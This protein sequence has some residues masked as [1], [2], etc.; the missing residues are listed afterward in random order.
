MWTQR[1][2]YGNL[3]A[4]RAYPASLFALLLG[5][6]SP[7][8]ADLDPAVFLTPDLIGR[9]IQSTAVALDGDTLWFCVTAPEEVAG[10]C[11]RVRLWGISAPEM[12]R[13]EGWYARAALDELLATTSSIACFPRNWH[14]NRL[15]AVCISGHYVEWQNGFGPNLAARLGLSPTYPGSPGEMAIKPRAGPDFAW[16]MLA[17]GWATEY[18]IFTRAGIETAADFQAER[19]AGY[20]EAERWAREQR[21]G[22]WAGMPD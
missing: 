13:P 1:A 12:S 2:V 9:G 3:R 22:V 18:R 5:A 21:N 8:A 15:V 20:A 19:V 7:R 16:A 17:L 11:L 4:M 10:G 6:A 14:K